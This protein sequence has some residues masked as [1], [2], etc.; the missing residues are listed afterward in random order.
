MRYYPLQFA[1]NFL[2][3]FFTFARVDETGLSANQNDFSIDS[4]GNVCLTYHHYSSADT[5]VNLTFTGDNI[6]Y[7]L[8]GVTHKIT[9]PLVSYIYALF[10]KLQYDV[11]WMGDVLASVKKRCPPCL[12]F[13]CRDIIL[14]HPDMMGSTFFAPHQSLLRK[15]FACTIREFIT[16]KGQKCEDHI[17]DF[18]NGP[19]VLWNMYSEQYNLKGIYSS[20]VDQLL[21]L[22]TIEC[23]IHGRHQWKR[24]SVHDFYC[25]IEGLYVLLLD[26]FSNKYRR[27]NLYIPHTLHQEML[28]HHESHAEFQYHQT[29]EYPTNYFIEKDMLNTLVHQYWM[30]QR[31]QEKKKVMK[32]AD[33]CLHKL[34]C[35]MMEKRLLITFQEWIKHKEG[36]ISKYFQQK[37]FKVLWQMWEMLKLM[38]DSNLTFQ[39]K[40]WLSQI[41][42]DFPLYLYMRCHLGHFG[43]PS[44]LS[45][46]SQT[47]L[48]HYVRLFCNP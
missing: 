3:L 34:T 44:H 19:N 36:H 43:R 9:Q 24:L 29:L 1:F 39:Q 11:E 45:S 23:L 30:P 33:Q 25:Q 4:K 6:L 35:V 42:C 37:N 32:L 17:G 47:I 15:Y 20:S 10:E 5:I 8:H 16:G 18:L 31:Y 13:S 22:L 46:T 14:K 2:E 41:L 7:K 26:V 28:K 21:H 12:E 48:N 40:K 27:I 38:W